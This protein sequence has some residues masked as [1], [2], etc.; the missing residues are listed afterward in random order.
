MDVVVR[1]PIF[2]AGS[3]LVVEGT[4][5][6]VGSAAGILLTPA[7]SHAD[8]TVRQVADFVV[9]HG[10]ALRVA[11]ED[12]HAALVLYAAVADEA[13]ADHV[14]PHGQPIIRRVVVVLPHVTDLDGAAGDI[15]E[16][17]ARDVAPAAAS[18]DV[19]S[20]PAEAS[21]RAAVERDP[22]HLTEV[23]RL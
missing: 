1:N 8:A 14:L 22:A 20:R 11:D 13:V 21:E 17:A 6:L 12:T 9:G 15:E 23:L 2:A 5:Y 19:Q 7:P 10:R 16:V 4:L 3:G 18:L